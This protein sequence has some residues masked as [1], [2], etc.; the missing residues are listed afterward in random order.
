VPKEFMITRIGAKPGEKCYISGQA[1]MGSAYALSKLQDDNTNLPKIPYHPAARIKEGKI[2][3]KFASCCMDTSDG[4]IHTLDTLM[5]LNHCQFVLYDDW[6]EIL[7]PIVLE[8]CNLRNMSPWIT[9][10]GVHGE[11][12]LCFT[13]NSNVEKEFL[14]EAKKNGGNPIQIGE[15]MQGEAVCIRTNQELVPIDTGMIRNL[16]EQAGMS[17][18]DYI[19]ELLDAAR[20]VGI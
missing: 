5:R 7:H 19:R 17:H 16:S 1:G 15:V 2:I 9:L 3:R 12:E 8:M 18:Q 14:D 13:V 11:F 6:E 20:K 4:V 10:A